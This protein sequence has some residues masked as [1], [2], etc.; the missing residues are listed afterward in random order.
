MLE[1]T[2]HNWMMLNV[3]KNSLQNT[4]DVMTIPVPRQITE[5]HHTGF[6]WNGGT[7]LN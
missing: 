4:E 1:Q 7:S 3:G 5:L 6:A 2:Q